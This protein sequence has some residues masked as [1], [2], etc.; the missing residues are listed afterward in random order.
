MS[1]TGPRHPPCRHQSSDKPHVPPDSERSHLLLK[2]QSVIVF[3]LLQLMPSTY[4][5]SKNMNTCVLIV[6]D[7]TNYD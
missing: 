3:L 6:Q 1:D 4:L 2:L 7:N 5:Q